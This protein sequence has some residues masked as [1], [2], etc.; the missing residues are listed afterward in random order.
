MERHHHVDTPAFLS[1]THCP[2]GG[3]GDWG[4]EGGVARGTTLMESSPLTPPPPPIH[5]QGIRD[6]GKAEHDSVG[7]D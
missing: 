3:G 5:S 1:I 6:R 7:T 4:G 2:C